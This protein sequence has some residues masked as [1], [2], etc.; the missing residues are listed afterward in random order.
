MYGVED[1]LEGS[2][3]LVSL[4]INDGSVDTLTFSFD[5]IL[6]VEGVEEDVTEDFD[7]FWCIFFQNCE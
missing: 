5:L 4:E 7:G 6:V 3:H 2:G 1:V